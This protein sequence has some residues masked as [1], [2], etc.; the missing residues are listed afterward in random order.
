M[1]S[2]SLGQTLHVAASLHVL[3]HFLSDASEEAIPDVI[4]E[5]AIVAAI[6]FIEVC[7]HQTAFTAGREQEIKLID[8]GNLIL[9]HKCS[10]LYFVLGTDQYCTKLA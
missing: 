8:A 10:V 7:C 4:C 9:P 2:K 6:D 3:F 1:L 5:Q